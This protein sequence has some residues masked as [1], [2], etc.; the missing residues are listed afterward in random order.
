MML[1][2]IV[3]IDEHAW[4]IMRRMFEVMLLIIVFLLCCP[5][6]QGGYCVLKGLARA[7]T[8]T[9]LRCWRES[10]ADRVGELTELDEVEL[11]LGAFSTYDGQHYGTLL[12]HIN[13]LP[14][15]LSDYVNKKEPA[16]KVDSF[17]CGFSF[18]HPDIKNSL[19]VEYQI[20]GA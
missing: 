20:N 1:L 10:N 3:G 13:A 4:K 5:I 6:A 17:L 2:N 8:G 18:R 14:N 12:T 7:F 9:Y 19:E 15:P 11:V 16:L